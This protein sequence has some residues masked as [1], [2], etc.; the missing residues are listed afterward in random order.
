MAITKT[1]LIDNVNKPLVYDIVPLGQLI[2]PRMTKSQRKAYNFRLRD[3]V[4]FAGNDIYVDSGEE[5]A[6]LLR[7]RKQIADQSKRHYHAQILFDTDKD[8][9]CWDYTIEHK[10]NT[11]LLSVGGGAYQ[12]KAPISYAKSVEPDTLA[13]CVS[14]LGSLITMLSVGADRVCYGYGVVLFRFDEVNTTWGT[15]SNAVH[16]DK[17]PHALPAPIQDAINHHYGY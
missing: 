15:A 10:W 17:S 7:Q 4:K 9:L 1:V 8:Q 11:K 5:L 2:Q 14:E 16:Y 12:V 3:N 6:V 13:Y